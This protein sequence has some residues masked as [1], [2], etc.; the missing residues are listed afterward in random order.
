VKPVFVTSSLRMMDGVMDKGK[1]LHVYVIGAT[2][3]PWALDW[4]FIRRFQKRIM[5]P[6]ARLRC[7]PTHDET[8]HRT[9]LT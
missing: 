7:P 9:T 8:V 6:L 1:K 4:P 5:V 2:N 3:K